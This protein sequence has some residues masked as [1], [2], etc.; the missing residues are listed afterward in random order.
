MRLER[1]TNEEQSRVRI[2]FQFHKGAI[3][4]SIEQAYVKTANNFNSIKVR[5]EHKTG[6]AMSLADFNFNSIKVRLELEHSKASI[7]LLFSFQFHKGAIRT[8]ISSRTNAQQLY[9]NSIK[10]RLEPSD[11]FAYYAVKLFQFHKGAI[12]TGTAD[13]LNIA[14]LISIP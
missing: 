2:L 1:I 3:R 7:N 8:R 11:F 4:T 12:R 6:E 5:L 9:F 14:S 10:V 13:E